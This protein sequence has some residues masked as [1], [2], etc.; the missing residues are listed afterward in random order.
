MPKLADQL[1]GIEIFIYLF[2]HKCQFFPPPQKNTEF[3]VILKP[4]NF[5]H[6]Y[7]NQIMKKGLLLHADN[8]IN[9]T[10]DKEK[11]S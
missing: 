8:R 7:K 5:A 11:V 3:D 9:L 4:E 2:F 1:Q 10:M 6:K